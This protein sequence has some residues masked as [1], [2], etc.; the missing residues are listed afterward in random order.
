MPLELLA[1]AVAK[2][3]YKRPDLSHLYTRPVRTRV[4]YVMGAAR[5][6]PDRHGLFR[7]PPSAD[8]LATLVP[9]AM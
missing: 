1:E 9:G 8:D 4:G 5:Y 2:V 6:L 7:W 3:R